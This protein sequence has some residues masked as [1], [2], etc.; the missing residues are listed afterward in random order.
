MATRDATTSEDTAAR[1]RPWVFDADGH[2][3]EPPRV[4]DDLLPARFRDYAPRVLQS[5]GHYRFACGDR[6]GFRI[7]GRREAVGAPGQT[8]QQ[9]DAPVAG[10]RSRPRASWTWPSTTSTPPRCTRRTG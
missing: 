4:W 10:D 6:V 5:E 2:V 9:T 7:D 3:V 1:T 8:P